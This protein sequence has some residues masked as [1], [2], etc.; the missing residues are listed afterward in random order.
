MKLP[1]NTERPLPVQLERAFRLFNKSMENFYEKR[2]KRTVEMCAEAL[3][4]LLP[5]RGGELSSPEELS[6]SF[7]AAYSSML[8]VQE[9]EAIAGVF[10]FFQSRRA[11]FQFRDGKPLPDRDWWQF[12]RISRE[13]AESVLEATRLALN[14]IQD[15]TS[16]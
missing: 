9:A 11:R 8:P 12:I 13:E 16:Q 14:A 10:T 6:D 1:S 2:Y 7:L 5:E 3:T 15:F 4:H